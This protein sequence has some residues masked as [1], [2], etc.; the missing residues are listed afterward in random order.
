VETNLAKQHRYAVRSAYIPDQALINGILKDKLK[1][2][3]VTQS[4][5][6]ISFANARK[7]YDAFMKVDFL[8]AANIFMT[9]TPSVSDIVLPVATTNE[10]DTISVFTGTGAPHAL[11]KIVDPP[12]EAR[13]DVMILNDLAKR[14]GLGEYF[15]DS[16][17]ETINYHLAHA[18]LTWEELKKLRVVHHKEEEVAEEGGF[19]TTPTGKGEIYSARAEEAFGCDPLPRWK[20]VQPTHDLSEEYPLF[21]TSYEDHDYHLTKFKEIKYFRKR[22]PY[23]TVQLN[24]ETAQKIGAKEGDWIWIES[25]LGRI[26]QKLVIDPE[27][28][29]KLVMTTFGWYFPEDPTNACQWDKANINILIPDGPEEESSGSVDTRGTPCRVYKAEPSEVGLPEYVEGIQAV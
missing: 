23:P 6:L 21:M 22:K 9:P 25:K 15:F 7:T 14:L 1:A 24:P 27:I 4:E 19:F 16:D 13:S 17:V 2:V 20:D 28:D 12:G 8:V 29:P 3:L 5:P 11:P 18:D 10:C 26:M